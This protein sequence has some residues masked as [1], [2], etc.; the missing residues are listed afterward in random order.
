MSLAN[1]PPSYFALAVYKVNNK[2]WVDWD[3][4]WTSVPKTMFGA[5]ATLNWR[6]GSGTFLIYAVLNHAGVQTSWV[7]IGKTTWIYDQLGRLGCYYTL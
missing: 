4:T 2:S 7:P 1:S 5:S 6:Y 3:T